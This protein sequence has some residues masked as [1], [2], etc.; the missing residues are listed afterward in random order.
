MNIRSPWF[1]HGVL[2]TLEHVL[3]RG[4]DALSTLVLLWTLQPELFSKLAIAQ[5]WAAPLLLLFI[6]PE[7]VLYRDYAKW[8]AQGVSAVASRLRAFRLFAW[9]KF[10]FAIIVC[11][12]CAG[13]S[14]GIPSIGETFLDRFYALTW[15]LGLFLVGHLSGPD[16][17]FLRLDL[18]LADLNAVTLLQ[19]AVFLIGIIAVSYFF[20]G[21]IAPLVLVLL[22]VALITAW[23][24]QRRSSRALRVQTGRTGE[25]QAPTAVKT[26]L[27]ESLSSFSLWQH[28]NGVLLGWI[29]TMDLFFIGWLLTAERSAGLYA[30]VLKLAN[31]TLFLPM[32]LSNLFMIWVGRRAHAGQGNE[33]REPVELMKLSGWLLGFNVAQA[34]V[35]ILGSSWFFGILSHGRWSQDEIEQMSRW[36]IFV[37]GGAVIQGTAFLWFSWLLIRAKVQELFAVVYLPWALVSLI[38][39]G[40]AVHYGG[41][42]W[43]AR[44]NVAVSLAYL[45]LLGAYTL[46]LRRRN[47]ML[48]SMERS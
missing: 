31:F 22:L 46:T 37:L 28:G 3:V 47:P 6:S 19:K 7:T 4:A 18:R 16:R 26:V 39:Y 36:L 1:K 41:I 13:L 34:L 12:A 11:A 8:K 15:G 35:L 38:L 27:W 45:V 9:G 32:A 24:A 33:G 14:R 23:A 30:A 10:L 25:A 44:S 2:N 20:P 48:F 5:A 42:D 29:Q 40:Y 17:E 43:A 21:T